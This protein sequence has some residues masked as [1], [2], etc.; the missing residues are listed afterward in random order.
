MG[1][2][3]APYQFVDQDDR[4]NAIFAGNSCTRCAGVFKG[5]IPCRL[6]L[7]NQGGDRLCRDRLLAE[8]RKKLLQFGDDCSIGG[9]SIQ[10][11][12]DQQGL[13]KVLAGRRI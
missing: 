13:G 5:R 7:E 9:T 3:W 11:D 2:A 4:T 8:F 10:S 6:A 12:K 1:F